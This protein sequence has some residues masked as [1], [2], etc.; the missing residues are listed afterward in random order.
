MPTRNIPEPLT[1]VLEVP[2]VGKIPGAMPSAKPVPIIVPLGDPFADNPHNLPYDIPGKNPEP[3]KDPDPEKEPDEKEPNDK[4]PTEPD[5]SEP[6]EEMKLNSDVCVGIPY[7]GQKLEYIFGNATG[8]KNHIER[9]LAMEI[10]LNSIG[11]FDDAKGKKLVLDNLSDAF[12]NPSSIIKTQGN[13][14]VVRKSILTGPSGVLKI[15]SLWDAERLI[16]IKLEEDVGEEPEGNVEDGDSKE[17]SGNDLS[18]IKELDDI[19]NDPS[20]LKGIKPEDLHQ[21]LK[22]K[23]YN[24]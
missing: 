22:E 16:T 12:D 15:E 6:D 9:S 23:G 17:G 8:N 1:R 24:P 14:R 18:N 4:E 19:L 13:G 11:I 21:Y 5:C 10:Q 2:D 3:E 20:I 7:Y